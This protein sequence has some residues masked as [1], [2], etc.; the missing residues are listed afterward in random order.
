MSRYSALRVFAEGLRG[1]YR[2][3]FSWPGN[4]PPTVVESA[5]K[6]DCLRTGDRC[7]SYF[8][9]PSGDLP[10]VFG[11]GSWTWK[12]EGDIMCP[13]S[14]DSAHVNSSG[15]D[16]LPQPPQDPIAQL[17]GHGHKEQSAPCEMN[18]DF[19]ETMTRVGD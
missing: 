6:T 15:Q 1:Q 11:G 5:V 2:R 14:A 12:I 19:Q 8:H 10:M 7:M 16:P 17:T 4:R 3:T 18:A 13:R 9:E